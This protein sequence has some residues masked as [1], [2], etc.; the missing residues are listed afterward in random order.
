MDFTFSPAQAAIIVNA[1]MSILAVIAT[2]IATQPQW[3]KWQKFATSVVI[4]A[5]LAFGTAYAQGKLVTNFWD[6]LFMIFTFGQGIYIVFKQAGIE[7][8]FWP[9]EAILSKAVEQVKQEVVQIPTDTAKDV[10]NP[11]N[12]LKLVTDVTVTT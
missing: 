2:Y 12:P 6:N 3:L 9:K 10:L 7:A 4:T 11:Q 8:K 1:V 5:L